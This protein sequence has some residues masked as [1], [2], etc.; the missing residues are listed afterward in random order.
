M[1]EGANRRNV[2]SG[3][4]THISARA[5]RAGGQD[6]RAT[7]DQLERELPSPRK[8]S[9]VGAE[10]PELPPPEPPGVSERLFPGFRTEYLQ[11]SGARIRVLSQG[12]GPPLL[13]LHGHPETHVTWH[14]VAPALTDSYTVIAPDLRGYGDSS[15]PDYSPR[16]QEYSFRAMAGDMV[17]VMGRLGY[18]QFMVAGH[19]RGGRVVHRMMLDHPDAVAKGAVLDVVPTLTMYNDTSK[20]FATKYVW[21]FF[22]IQPAP[23]PEHLISLDPGYYLRDHLAVQCKTPGAVTPDAMAEYIRCYCCKGSIRAACEDYRAAAGID[24]EQDRADDEADRKIKAPL[25]ALWGGQGTVGKL[26][27]VLATWR[28]KSHAAV[29]GQ[30]LPCGHLIPEE[31]PELTIALF[32]RFFV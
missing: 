25:L 15:K 29:E 11:A 9:P 23:T 7:P 10:L 12:S 14:K 21:W 6:M 30:A 20:E 19:D 16:S 18:K 13:L 8:A 28:P 4:A 1:T 2:A 5:G 22:Q 17:E 26:W 32:R 24:L 27:D 31:Q 3:A